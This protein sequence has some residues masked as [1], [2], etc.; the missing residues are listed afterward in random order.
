MST[1]INL[2][3]RFLVRLWA[4]VAIFVMALALTLWIGFREASSRRDVV[5]QQ[6]IEQASRNIL[7]RIDF[8]RAA[9]EQLAREP[10]TLDELILGDADSHHAWAETRLRFIPGVLG[11]ALVDPGGEVHGDA[12]ALRVG[13][14]CQT[15]LR[16]PGVLGSP[17]LFVHREQAELAH[18]DLSVLVH[19]PGGERVGGLLVSLLFDQ[20][21]RVVE[22]SRH[23]DHEIELADSAGQTIARTGGWRTDVAFDEVPLADTGWRLRVAKPEPAMTDQEIALIVITFVALIGVL[24]IMLEGMGRLRRNINRD[25]AMIRDGLGAIATDAPLP[26]LMPTYA[27]FL[28]AMQEIE[29]IASEIHRQRAEFARLS[30][31]DALTGLPNRRALEGRFAQMLGFAQRGHPIALALLDLDHFK[32]LNDTQGHAAGDRALQALAAT[33]TAVSR[34]ADFAARLAGDEFVMVLTGLDTEGASS[35]W[36]QRLADHFQGQLRAAGIDAKLGISGGLVWLLPNDTLG[37]ALTRADRAL[38]RAKAE[39]RCRLALQGEEDA[40]DAR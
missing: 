16:K 39:G 29:R 40:G 5:L 8:Y 2:K 38:Y 11:L 13:P 18:F 1:P 36:Y 37:H 3:R 32:S 27:Q 35:A 14:Q 15:D 23:P 12:G 30:L 20:L 10:A 26:S 21:Q 17:R 34:S 4:I 6:Q 22:D 28:P 31:S 7:R 33:L 24:A 9:A 19:G 25:L